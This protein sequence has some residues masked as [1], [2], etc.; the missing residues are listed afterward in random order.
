VA[1]LFARGGT[2]ALRAVLATVREGGDATA[3]V[4]RAY[5]G[6]GSWKDFERAWRQ[7]MA[8]QRYKTLSGLEPMTPK[9]KKKAGTAPPSEDDAGT[10]LGEAERY[11]RLGNMMLLRNRLRPASME[12]EK[13]HR[14]A[15]GSHWLF[16]VKLGRTHLALG[17][18]AEAGRA[19]AAAA[20]MYPELPWPHL[21]AGQAA[22]A[23]GDARQAAL[24]LLRALAINPY[25][26]AVHCGLAEAYQRLPDAPAEKRTRAERDCRE[27]RSL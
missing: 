25:D 14:L 6:S 4:G 10:G 15:G 5:G 1:C 17:E 19:V 22:L 18:P 11:L 3:A 8:A 23:Q 12:Y 27:L 21:I 9:Y 16:A 7:F 26:P 20:G 13:G 24:S 2:A